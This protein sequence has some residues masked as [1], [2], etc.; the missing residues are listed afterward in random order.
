MC[1]NLSMCT[2]QACTHAH[3]HTNGALLMFMKVSSEL[4]MSLGKIKIE[5]MIS[6]VSNRR[7][8]IFHLDGTGTHC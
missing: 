3:T 1:T 7:V 8:Y 4:N 2:L 5:R 6:Y